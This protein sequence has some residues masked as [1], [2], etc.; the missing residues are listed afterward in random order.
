MSVSLRHVLSQG[1]VIAA[2]ART[3]A[4]ALGAKKPGGPAPAVPGP[5]IEIEAPPRPEDLVRDYIRHVG[6]DVGSYRKTVPA[7]MFPQWAFALTG[8][9]LA[10]LNYPFIKAMNGGCRLEMR[11]PLPINEAL[12]I[13]ARLESIDDNGKRAILTQRVITGTKSAPDA[14]VADMRVFI[15][16]P[17]PAEPE[18]AEAAPGNGNGHA[19]A[20]EK[21]A[22]RKR[23]KKKKSGNGASK[24]A[25]STDK[26][27]SVPAD[28]RE[29]AWQKLRPDAGLDF[30]KL[31]GDF[32]PIHWIPAAA[33]ASGFRS[34]ILHG[35]STLARTIEALNRRLYAGDVSRLGWIDARFTRPLV[36]PATIGVYAHDH[37]VYV[38]DAPG[39][40]A[41]LEATFAAKK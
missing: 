6:G 11:A 13:R 38:G 4:A 10:G 39:G 5:W 14:V 33:H 24:K 26:R 32:N 8:K 12:Q 19:A 30:A 20:A 2:L 41:Y 27:P 34:V 40:G 25:A 37:H 22:P 35:F 9:T 1:P 7:H 16:L 17:T 15:P 31:T 18:A 36:L 23:G 3:A 21:P 28:A 29:L